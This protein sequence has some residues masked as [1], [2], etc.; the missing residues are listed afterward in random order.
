MSKKTLILSS[1]GL[2]N[3]IPE[4]TQ[5]DE[6]QFIFGEKPIYTK[7]VFAEFISPKV[8]KMHKID[9]TI[10]SIFFFDK[11]KDVY[12]TD[13]TISNIKL[14]LLNGSSIEINEEESFQLKIISILLDNESYFVN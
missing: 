12:I 5:E 8:S 7:N 11:Y 3:I 9:P 14:L 13:E 10:N 4:A 1:A 6:F 2:K